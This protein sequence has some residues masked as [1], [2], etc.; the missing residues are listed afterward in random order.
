MRTSTTLTATALVAAATVALAGCGGAKSGSASDAS[1]VAASISQA[2][3]SATDGASSGASDSD[4]SGG[5]SQI[6]VRVANLYM[7]DDKKPGPALDIYD[8]PLNG[9]AATPILK[10]VAYGTFSDYV[11]PHFTTDFSKDSIALEAL[12][13]GSDP[14]TD[15]SEAVMLT[16]RQDDGSHPQLTLL[17]VTGGDGED[18]SNPLDALDTTTYVE[19]GDI[20]GGSGLVPGNNAGPAAPAP[21][22]GQDELLA[23]TEVLKANGV[24]G[25]DYYLFVDSSCT[26]PLNG[27]P[28]SPG[29]PEIFASN[30]NGDAPTNFAEFPAAAGT[31]QVS[32]VATTS[33]DTPTCASLTAKTG[34]TSA[35]LTAGQQTLAFVYGTSLSDLH[36]ALGPIQ[37]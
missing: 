24:P 14:T 17:L 11:H 37:Q 15:G 32:V 4:A 23:S 35:T 36:I 34:T 10:D 28:N 29:L 26:A 8:V 21:P 2:I 20:A 18:T 13:S 27:D 33:F 7:T 12:P 31:H 16:G 3:G 19:K 30:P 22:S 9:Q 25:D 1:K 5:T 6:S